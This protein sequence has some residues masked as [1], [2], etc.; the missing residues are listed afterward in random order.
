MLISM[1][2]SKVEMCVMAHLESRKPTVAE[3]FFLFYHLENTQ[4]DI[5]ANADHSALCIEVLKFANY[6]G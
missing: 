4:Q 6:P 1:T 5:F 2:L 3:F